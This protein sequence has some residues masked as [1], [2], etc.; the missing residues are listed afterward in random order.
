MGR[1]VRLDV[2]PQQQK[3]VLREG[4]SDEDLTKSYEE[5]ILER[6]SGREAREAGRS[7]DDE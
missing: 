4:I 1:R 6:E 7:S 3:M 2:K 5:Y